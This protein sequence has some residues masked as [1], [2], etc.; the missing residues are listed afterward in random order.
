MSFVDY[1]PPITLSLIGATRTYF[2]SLPLAL[3][4]Y[5]F[6]TPTVTFTNLT[7][8]AVGETKGDGSNAT[9]TLDTDAA[10]HGWYI[11]Y[12]P[13]LNEDFL[14]TSNPN[15]W[16]AKAGSDAAGKMDMLSVLLHEYGHALGLEHSIDAHDFMAT[17]LTPGMRRLPSADELNLMAQLV[18][19]AK[20]NLASSE[21][22]AAANNATDPTPSIPTLPLGAGFGISFLGLMRRNN[23]SA[24]SLL[25]E[26]LS[27]SKPV[28]YICAEVRGASIEVTR[29]MRLPSFGSIL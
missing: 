12:T 3:G 6:T 10:G 28:P 15:E 24:S 7:G 23:G 26:S 5:N 9:I 1:F 20:Q 22:N 27:A 29:T 17:T 4:A 21:S 16:V 19:E 2:I 25:S 11:D 13:Y 14:P 18:A 8:A